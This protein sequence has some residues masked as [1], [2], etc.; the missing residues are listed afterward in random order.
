MCTKGLTTARLVGRGV[1]R[2]GWAALL[3]NRIVFSPSWEWE[4]V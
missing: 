3:V 2:V 1:A 4:H